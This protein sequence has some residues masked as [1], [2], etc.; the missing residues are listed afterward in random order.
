MTSQSQKSV[1]QKKATRASLLQPQGF[2]R[3]GRDI[4]HSKAYNSTINV[5]LI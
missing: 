4:A 2:I 5:K 3:F 1:F